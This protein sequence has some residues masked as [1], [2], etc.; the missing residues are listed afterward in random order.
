MYFQKSPTDNNNDLKVLKQQRSCFVDMSLQSRRPSLSKLITSNAHDNRFN[1]FDSTKISSLS[2]NASP[3]QFS[4]EKQTKRK[5]LWDSGSNIPY[6]P[7]PGDE[8]AMSQVIKYGHSFRNDLLKDSKEL[9]YN[10]HGNGLQKMECQLTREGHSLR[11]DTAVPEDLD[12]YLYN[13]RSPQAARKA[14]KNFYMLSPIE[15]SRTDLIGKNNKALGFSN[16]VS[17]EISPNSKIPAFMQ[18]KGQYN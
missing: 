14:R 5:D 4:F 6:V 13:I 9:T 17:R 8:H 11:E 10:R 16:Q 18:I 15:K 3:R 7:S 12:L 1:Y 2:K